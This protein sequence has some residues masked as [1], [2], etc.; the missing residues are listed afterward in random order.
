MSQLTKRC[1]QRVVTGGQTGVD[2]AAL[3][4]C[5]SNQIPCSGWCPRGRLAEDGRISSTYPLQET[6][7]EEYSQRTEWNV[8]DSDGTLV[9]CPGEPEGGTKLTIELAEK[10][11]K[12]YL[13]IDMASPRSRK[14]DFKVWCHDHDVRVLNVAG[15]R[16]S[17]QPGS[18]YNR[19]RQL[20]AELFDLVAGS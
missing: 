17:L 2:R 20:M 8:R 19:S 5:L 14:E 9:I 11:N 4:L 18:I 12:P 13:V 1:F 10:Y 7:S 15:P 3:D 16:E 6:P